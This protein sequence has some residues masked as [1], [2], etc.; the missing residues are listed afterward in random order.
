[1]TM[2]NQPIAY[3]ATFRAAHTTRGGHSAVLV[4]SFPNLSMLS[5]AAVVVKFTTEMHC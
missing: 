2:P 3:P 4:K 1:M 5:N